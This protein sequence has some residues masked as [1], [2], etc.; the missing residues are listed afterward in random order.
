MRLNRTDAFWDRETR[1][2]INDN[3]DIIE[4]NSRK[5]ENDFKNVVDSITDEVVGQLVDSAKLDWEDPVDTYNDL[6]ANAE[7]GET[8]MVR[9]T[10][11]V[12]RF[13]GSAWVEIQQI[14]AGPVNEV[15]SRLTA[16]LAQIVQQ[17]TTFGLLSKNNYKVG[18]IIATSGFYNLFDNGGGVWSVTL[19]SGTEVWADTGYGWEISN[20]AEIKYGADKKLVFISASITT[21]QMGCKANDIDDDTI[22]LTKLLES[23]KFDEVVVS[24]GKHIINKTYNGVTQWSPIISPNVYTIKGASTNSTIKLGVGNGDGRDGTQTGFTAFFSYRYRPDTHIII[25]GVSFDFNADQNPLYHPSNRDRFYGIPSGSRQAVIEAEYCCDFTFTNNVVIDNQGTNAVIYMADKNNTRNPV[26]D[27]HDNQFLDVGKEGGIGVHDHS[28][29]YIHEVLPYE[30][31]IEASNYPHAF[32][33]NNIFTGYKAGAENAYCAIECAVS[34]E[35]YNNEISN[36]WYGILFA[37]KNKDNRV[38][39]YSNTF[40]NVANS[41]F[42]WAYRRSSTEIIDN[43]IRSFELIKLTNN[44]TYTDPSK[45]TK[46]LNYVE[47]TPDVDGYIIHNYSFIRNYGTD[48]TTNWGA[49]IVEGNVYEL[50]DTI[51]YKV[52][53]TLAKTCLPIQLSGTTA[54][55]VRSTGIKIE[56]IEINNNT[57]INLPFSVLRLTAFS[58]YKKIS[59]TKN[60]VDGCFN[61]ASVFATGSG[62]SLV[63]TLIGSASNPIENGVE[64]IVIAD[65]HINVGNDKMYRLY[66]LHLNGSPTKK[67]NITIKN[68]DVINSPYESFLGVNSISSLTI[69]DTILE[70]NASILSLIRGGISV[71]NDKLNVRLRSHNAELKGKKFTQ[72]LPVLN[73][74]STSATYKKGDVVIVD[75]VFGQ[76][77]A[78]VNVSDE[79]LTWN[80]ISTVG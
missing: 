10:G 60:T 31:G 26:I 63:F 58:H 65:N 16:Q 27:L 30:S 21:K 71:P 4:G 77:Y 53:N 34:A 51:D 37:T 69:D 75:P 19:L 6:P 52:D 18:D 41:F 15:D 72:Y 64:N 8:R 68:N 70:L 55:S 38:H 35:L 23:A 45:L 36:Y 9:D 5:L 47:Y 56:R 66:H 1:N 61:K 44:K 49:V 32:I 29:I 48:V 39:A 28:T 76:P 7:V 50:S 62:R 14:D 13:N 11:K 74:Y 59:F 33:Y 40:Y 54:Q 79:T 46:E 12:Y 80:K 42:L 3:W 24:E 25:D 67:P 78:Y 43:E 73:D 20:D 2:G 57:F 22:V 17:K